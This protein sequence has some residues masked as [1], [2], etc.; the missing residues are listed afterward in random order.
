MFKWVLTLLLTTALPALAADSNNSNV[1]SAADTAIKTHTAAGQL[2][3]GEKEWVY[4]APVDHN[5]RS[6]VDTGA[7]TSSI[8]AIDIK[9]YKKDGKDMADFKLAHKDW[10][11]EPL[12]RRVIRW[13]EIKQSTGYEEG[14]RPVVELEVQI[15]NV[16]T[17]TEF[18]LTDR[19]HLSYPILLG[20]TFI[21]KQAI[22]DVSHQYIQPKAKLASPATPTA[23]K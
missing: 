15:G 10:V 14:S 11:S 22:V 23:A 13:V 5:L 21:D 3:L 8:G 4:I 19:S 7:T 12:T 1:T 9:L 18:T 6:R 16:K 17:T 20:R 2:L